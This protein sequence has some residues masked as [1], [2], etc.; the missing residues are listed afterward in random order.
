[1]LLNL[2]NNC[3]IKKTL[4]SSPRSEKLKQF[5]QLDTIKTDHLVKKEEE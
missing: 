1:M 2:P 3:D 4:K 5:W